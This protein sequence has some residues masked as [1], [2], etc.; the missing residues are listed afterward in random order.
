MTA[1]TSRPPTDREALEADIRGE[2]T[3]LKEV[4]AQFR[5]DELKD[6][7]WFTGFI[8]Y[9]LNTYADTVDAAWIKAKYPGLPPDAIVERRIQLAARA[10]ALDLN[11]AM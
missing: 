3:E 5:P 11:Q 7:S 4:A 6:G 10:A 9:A 8:R 2:L 1:T